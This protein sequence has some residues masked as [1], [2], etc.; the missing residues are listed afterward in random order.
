MF[1]RLM[2]LSDLMPGDDTLF[3]PATKPCW[4]FPNDHGLFEVGYKRKFTR[5]EN[6]ISI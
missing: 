4:T 3:I 1:Y 6:F 5:E 2:I